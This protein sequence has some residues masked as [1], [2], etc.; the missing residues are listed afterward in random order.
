MPKP[1]KLWPNSAWWLL[2]EFFSGW[3]H[4]SSGLWLKKKIREAE[5]KSGEALGGVVSVVGVVWGGG[6]GASCW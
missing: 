5:I 3:V 6:E 2:G 4:L 1:Q